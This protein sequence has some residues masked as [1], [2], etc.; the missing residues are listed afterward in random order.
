[1]RFSRRWRCR[2]QRGAG[3]PRAAGE[4]GG[5]VSRAREIRIKGL[6]FDGQAALILKQLERYNVTFIGIDTTGVGK[7]VWDIVVK[8]YPTA[9]R[10]DYNVH[11]KTRMV[12]KAKQVIMARRFQFDAGDKDILASFMS[13]RAELTPSQRQLTYTASRAGDTGHA[14]VA[15]AIMHAIDNE[16]LEGGDPSENRATVEMY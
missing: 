15:W 10:I 5:S 4:G 3:D 12:L 9:K 7:A 11:V 1:M 2:R 8:K 14:D 16:P 6:G 13:I